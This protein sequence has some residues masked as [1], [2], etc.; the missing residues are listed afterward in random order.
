MVT[1]I[2]RGTVGEA[3]VKPAIGTLCTVLWWDGHILLHAP[4]FTVALLLCARVCVC[5]VRAHLYATCC[6]WHCVQ[7]AMHGF[8]APPL[9][10]VWLAVPM[11]NLV[12]SIFCNYTPCLFIIIICCL[13]SAGDTNF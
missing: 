8:S 9:L 7:H 2:H 10:R 13:L 11:F 4:T 1:D 6:V 5:G 3:V 12:L